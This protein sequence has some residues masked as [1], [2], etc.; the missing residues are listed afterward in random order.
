MSKRKKNITKP[1][2]TKAER[3]PILSGRE[4]V[5]A[6]N[7]KGGAKK[8]S[9]LEQA[10]APSQITDQ[11]PEETQPAAIGTE[12]KP[13]P[14]GADKQSAAKPERKMSAL[15]AAAQVLA[16]AETPLNTKMI[17]ER[18]IAQGLWTT[19]GKTPSA[20]LFASLIREIATKGEQ[21]RFKKTDR[22]LF[23]LK[24]GQP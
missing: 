1:S 21:A 5:A 15:D 12:T 20:T 3:P 11:K 6:L 4:A 14:D 7:G 9:R 2:G 24:T 19:G 16:A 10:A 13:A 18:M 22:G 8:R 17:V 23:T